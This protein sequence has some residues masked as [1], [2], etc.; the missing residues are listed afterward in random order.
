LNKHEV[1]IK[2]T[3]QKMQ[4][5]L[6][7]LIEQKEFE[8]ITISE[9]CQLAG[10]NRTT[11][12]AHY[13]NTV[14]L[15]EE[16]EQDMIQ[17]FIEGQNNNCTIE[18]SPECPELSDGKLMLDDRILTAYLS[19]VRGHQRIFKIYTSKNSLFHNKEH[20]YQ[21]KNLFFKRGYQRYTEL[22][23]TDITYISLY[24]LAGVQA[25]LEQWINT[26]CCEEEKRICKIIKFC[27][28]K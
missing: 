19:F 13:C 1:K 6:I 20:F 17:N 22:S 14:E 5:A 16:L 23:D 10:V 15:L 3:A 12:Y 2:N 25:I 28:M 21:F 27:I 18:L 11:F 4:N 8:E 7:E 26:N 9:I 24:Y